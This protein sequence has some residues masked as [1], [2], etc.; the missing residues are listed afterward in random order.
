LGSHRLFPNPAIDF[1]NVEINWESET[2]DAQLQVVDA[3]GKRVMVTE[4]SL[5]NGKNSEKLMLNDIPAGNYW[6]YL[7]G[8]GW[9]VSLDKFVKVVR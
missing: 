6:V 1:V 8:A 4:M 9:E 3:A 2:T 5:V 7:A